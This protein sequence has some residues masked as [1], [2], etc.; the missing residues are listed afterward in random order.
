[1]TR[2]RENGRSEHRMKVE[3]AKDSSTL[4]FQI[5]SGGWGTNPGVRSILPEI[6]CTRNRTAL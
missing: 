2:S 1:M 6:Y 5:R 4:G 3:R